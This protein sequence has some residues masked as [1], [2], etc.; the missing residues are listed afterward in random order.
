M[1]VL[2]E[3]RYAILF[4][5]L[6]K[7]LKNPQNGLIKEN[8]VRFKRAK[9]WL[10]VGFVIFILVVAG[11]YWRSNHEF[12][13]QL[14]N[15][16]SDYLSR[17]KNVNMT[18]PERRHIG[19]LKIHKAGG[20]TI[21]NI[22]FRFGLKRQLNFVMPETSYKFDTYGKPPAKLIQITPSKYDIL[23]LHSVY[24]EATYASVLPNDS[25]NI[26]IV[27]EPLSLMISAAYYHR[28]IDGVSYLQTVPKDK[29]IQNLIRY[30]ELYD[31]E[32]LSL[33]RNSMAMDFGFPK[34]MHVTDTDRLQEFLDYLNSKFGLVMI[35]EYFDESL[36]LVKKIL[37]WKLEDIMYVPLNG[38]KHP[39]ESDL[40][41]TKID[42]SKFEE[43][44]FLDVAIY[45]YFLQKF[46]EL[47][48]KEDS[49]FHDEVEHFKVMRTELQTL[50]DKNWEDKQALDIQQSRW[51]ERFVI[52]HS[53]CD[54]MQTPE[55]TFIDYL[56]NTMKQ[57]RSR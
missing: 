40:Q 38:Y 24:N 52:T 9:Q 16:I 23:A 21:Q 19:F 17:C 7:K 1:T 51:N 50:C 20:S 36:V 42:K 30:P 41:I 12:F 26:A 53:D 39:S 5:V 44:N 6:P 33:T 4:F 3:K 25:I 29:F 35:F 57:N 15:S 43:R 22:L 10:V 47:V 45:K 11:L 18:S 32:D 31:K 13:H 54:F 49:D 8:T 34:G 48:S 14:S 46:K 55:L 27:R 2:T 37:N 28:D 56:R